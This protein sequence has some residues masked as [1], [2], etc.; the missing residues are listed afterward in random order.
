[1]VSFSGN[2][3]NDWVEDPKMIKDKLIDEEKCE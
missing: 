3:D 1:M 2:L